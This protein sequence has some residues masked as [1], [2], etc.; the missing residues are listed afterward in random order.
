MI[1]SGG[2]FRFRPIFFASVGKNR[3]NADKIFYFFSLICYYVTII[4]VL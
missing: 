3:K 1:K 4:G 2:A